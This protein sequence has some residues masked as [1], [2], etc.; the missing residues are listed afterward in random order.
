VILWPVEPSLTERL[1][2]ILS[3]PRLSGSVVS[4]CVAEGDGK[5]L[6]SRWDDVRVMPASNQKLLTCLFA[7]E[8]LGP[9]YRPRTRFWRLGDRLIVAAPG[10][11]SLTY[12]TLSEAAQRMRLPR[13]TRVQ[14]L[15]SYAPGIPETWELDDLPNRYAPAITAFTFDRG[16]FELWNENGRPRFRPN[17]FGVRTVRRAADKP[18][19]AYDPIRKT[20]TVGGLD[21][22]TGRLDTLAQPEPD[23]AAASLF[24]R[25]D[26]AVPTLPTPL[27]TLA[28]VGRPV[29]AMIAE[30]LPPSDN[31]Y[32]EH[33]GLMAATRETPGGY[34]EMR[35]AMTSFLTERV[36]WKPH[37]FRVFD[38]SGLSRHD[39]VTTGNLVDLLVWAD[40]RPH[41]AVWRAALA[42][43]GVGTLKGRLD[44]VAFEGKTGT[45][46]NV[47]ALSGYVRDRAGRGRIV[48]FVVNHALAPSSVVRGLIDDAVRAVAEA[49]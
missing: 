49:D 34:P 44:G 10:D 48:S 46:D 40:A 41:R 4:A 13:G 14:L 9:D 2:A 28:V 24:G 39:L 43:P 31:A 7:L 3:D 35:R 12:A 18:T 23:A 16:G 27:E 22:K 36:G 37:T 6:F 20:L 15:Q 1:N 30:C 47:V 26:R 33:L 25:I 38:G 8:T 17:S 5:R 21:R 29:S 19:W 11:P 42:R 32:A 45:V